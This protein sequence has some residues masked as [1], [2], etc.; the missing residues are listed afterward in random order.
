MAKYLTNG[1]I[2]DKN[3]YQCDSSHRMFIIMAIVSIVQIFVSVTYIGRKVLHHSITRAQ[4]K[5]KF[6]LVA[7]I[8][9]VIDV[10]IL[11]ITIPQITSSTDTCVT[12]IR[13]WFVANLII[14]FLLIPNI[15]YQF[16]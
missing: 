15:Y 10:V 11:V 6:I 14:L 3:V 16:T 1:E 5:K 7:L 8:L 12:L 13:P 9:S 2:T 4:F